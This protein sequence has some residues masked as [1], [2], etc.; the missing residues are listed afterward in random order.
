[1]EYQTS[2]SNSIPTSNSLYPFLTCSS[3]TAGHSSDMNNSTTTNQ[4]RRTFR[5]SLFSHHPRHIRANDRPGVSVRTIPGHPHL[6]PRYHKGSI[7]TDTPMSH[8]SRV[9]VCLC[10]LCASHLPP[11]LAWP[12]LGPPSE[13]KRVNRRDDVEVASKREL[14]TGLAINTDDQSRQRPVGWNMGIWSFVSRSWQS[15]C[16]GPCSRRG[17]SFLRHKS[18]IAID[19]QFDQFGDERLF[20]FCLFCHDRLII[21]N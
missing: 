3:A 7:E 4:H 12:V 20:V 9:C 16:P 18:T 13:R 2:T 5:S 19:G 11:P 15:S 6:A 1:M 21:Q 14:R 10:G 17:W 8:S